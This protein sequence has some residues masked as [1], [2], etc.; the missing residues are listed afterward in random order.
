MTAISWARLVIGRRLRKIL[1]VSRMIVHNETSKYPDIVTGFE[2]DFAAMVGVPHAATMS[3]GT[4]GLEAALFALGVGTG[5]EIIAPSYTIHSTFSAALVLGT[6]VRFADINPDTLTMEPREVEG[7]V[8]KRTKAIIVVHI[9]GNPVDMD[10][11]MAVAKRYNLKVIEDCSHCHGARW[12][13]RALGSIGDIGVFSLQGIKPVAAGEG[14]IVVTRCPVLLDR[15][16]AYGH[17]G[18][19]I[20][21]TLLQELETNFLPH[22]GLGR[23]CRANPLGIA[24]ARVDLDTLETY[25]RL[26]GEAWDFVREEL[27]RSSVLKV[28]T[29]QPGGTMAGFFQGCAVRIVHAGFTP[30]EIIRTL[31]AAK[32]AVTVFSPKPSHHMPHLYD[33]RYRDA[34]LRGESIEP[35]HPPCLPHTER[36]LTHVI[37]L[38]L[39]Q[40]A[41]R[42]CRA[43]LRSAVA[44][45]E[46]EAGRQAETETGR[47]FS[48]TSGQKLPQNPVVS[49]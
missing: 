37:F 36:A 34:Q 15:M 26:Y 44:A 30:E 49:R 38:P 4:S 22:T 16:L 2:R 9:W 48:A 17:Q 28:Q 39:P 10:G 11:I 8:T 27:S 25:N 5:D 46:A 23:K 47:H 21:G 6:A 35:T 41:R 31:S 43:R 7:L 12:G 32:V 40:F 3:N 20:S 29:P 33:R 42:V 45:L 13:N 1:M 18:R 19:R 14:G 24:L